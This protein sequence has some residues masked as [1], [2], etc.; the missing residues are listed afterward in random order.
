MLFYHRWMEVSIGYRKN[1]RLT[2]SYFCTP[3]MMKLI[4]QKMPMER[5]KWATFMY[6]LYSRSHKELC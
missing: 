2:A 1:P 4:T 5:F 3:N 6:Y